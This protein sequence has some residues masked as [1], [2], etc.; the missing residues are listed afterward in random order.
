MD[1]AQHDIYMAVWKL[2]F[3]VVPPPPP[4]PAK[5]NKKMTAKNNQTLSIFAF[6]IF[7]Y[8][9]PPPPPPHSSSFPRNHREG[10]G[11]TRDVHSRVGLKMCQALAAYKDGD[12]AEAVKLV[13]PLRYEICALGGSH[14]QVGLQALQN[15]S[16]W[17]VAVTV[18][19]GQGLL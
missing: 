5:Q 13:Y 19:H 4:T 8:F 9:S 18:Q 15:F 1:K 3:D 2:Y 7:T 17:F 11:T 10:Q 12:F 6:N 16:V 14:A